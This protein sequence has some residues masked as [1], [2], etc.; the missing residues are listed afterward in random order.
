MQLKH[1]IALICEAPDLQYINDLIR[2]ART[3]A[4]EAG[5][6]IVIMPLFSSNLSMPSVQNYFRH[7]TEAAVKMDAEIYI[8]SAGTIISRYPDHQEHFADM[9]RTLK[10]KKVLMIDDEVGD[11]PYLGKDNQSGML[12]LMDHLINEHHYTR[13]GM[14]AGSKSSYGSRMRVQAYE[15]MMKRYG[16]KPMV[17]HGNFTGESDEVVLSFLKE[18]P[19]LQCLV[20]ANDK[21]AICAYRAIR[22]LGLQ[23]G[24]DI[25]VTGFDD[26]T[27]AALLDPPLSTV[28]LDVARYGAQAVKEAIHIALGEPREMVV[29][30]ST[31]IQ[32]KSC[33][34]TSVNETVQKENVQDRD[35]W[36]EQITKHTLG[37]SD[38]R[39][40]SM[41]N[42]LI[43]SLE[44]RNG[45]APVR[46]RNG[47]ILKAGGSDSVDALYRS[48]ADYFEKN[49]SDLETRNAFHETFLNYFYNFSKDDRMSQLNRNKAILSIIEQ[50]FLH[51]DSPDEAYAGIFEI[52]RK[53]GCEEMDFYRKQED[54]SFRLRADVNP[55]GVHVSTKQDAVV[56]PGKWDGLPEGAWVASAIESGSELSG[57]LMVKTKQDDLNDV[58]LITIALGLAVHYL[59]VLQK[60]ENLI[61]LL[62]AN[63][64]TLKQEADYDTLTGL[65]N[66]RGFHRQVEEVWKMYEGQEAVLIFA[67]LDGLKN[68][69]DTYGHEEGD[70]ALET[71]ASLLHSS[72]RKGDLTARVGG[73]E[74]AVLICDDPGDGTEILKRIED[75]FRQFDE[76]SSK[77][78]Q[79]SVSCGVRHFTIDHA[80]PFDEIL[81]QADARLYEVKK[82]H[83]ALQGRN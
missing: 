72:M 3:A 10:G 16:M 11:F 62:N 53:R 20:C 80:V 31:F 74:F 37:H 77:P 5:W 7:I 9:I 13:I 14:I 1:T 22:S 57:I 34:H 30:P 45:A 28:R 60:E 48:L 63:N 6:T 70:F 61:Y 56:F 21:L 36:I 79:I 71:A 64:I 55:A 52:F 65:L 66:R 42:D 18:H 19:D 27:R 78:Y 51:G 15:V 59:S 82:Q 76:S 58:Y 50:A 2:G 23:V 83:H 17:A 44:S 25:A 47:G 49:G 29:F 40:S 4:E 81:K 39:F 73:D 8:L 26:I 43:T 67:D 24:T 46:H 35:A 12:E 54:G 69:N 33:G 75:S 68:I 38:H 41:V 32:R